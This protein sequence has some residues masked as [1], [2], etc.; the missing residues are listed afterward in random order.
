MLPNDTSRC[1]G[2]P[3]DRTSVRPIQYCQDCQRWR[4]LGTGGERTPSMQA[5]CAP[6]DGALVCDYRI[7]LPISIKAA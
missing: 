5:P 4:S 6:V 2:W 3:T 7:P 1:H